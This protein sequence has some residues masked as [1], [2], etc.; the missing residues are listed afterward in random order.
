MYF[1]T[2]AF[3]PLLQAAKEAKGH[4]SPSVIVISSMSGLM[5]HAQGHFSYNAAKG[6]TVRELALFPFHLFFVP[7]S[8]GYS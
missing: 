2:V 5:A 1:T 6:A 8:G 4:L 3:L 7:S